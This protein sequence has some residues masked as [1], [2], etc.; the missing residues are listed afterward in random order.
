MV[1]RAKQKGTAAEGGVVRFLRANGWPYA[2][3]RALTGSADQGD[4]TGCPG[5]VFEVKHAGTRYRMA[6]WMAETLAEQQNAKADHGILIIKPPGLGDRNVD[7]WHA[8]MQNY[9]FN[10]LWEQVVASPDMGVFVEQAEPRAYREDDV[11]EMLM[12]RHYD[13]APGHVYVMT[14][15]APGDAGTPE[16]WYRIMTFGHMLKMLRA[17]G[18]GTELVQDGAPA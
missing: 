18:Y 16:N 7:L 6:Q 9:R 3:R 15:M 5:L 13:R 11:R 4:V 12:S 1:N 17:A 2:E 10:L 14:A 8:V